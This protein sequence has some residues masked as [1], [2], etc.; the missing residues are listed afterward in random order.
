MKTKNS[1]THRKN[2]L[3]YVKKLAKD[4]HYEA[5]HT[6]QVT[7]TALKIFDD[8]QNLHRLGSTERFYLECAGILHDIGVHTQGTKGHHKAS[9]N[10]ILTTPILQFNNIER[11]IIGSVVR[12]HRRA[13]PSISHDHFK[14]L[15]E[16]ERKKV[17]I[18]AGILRIADGLDYT[19][20]RHVG[21]VEASFNDHKIIIDCLVRRKPIKK[22]LKS[23][24]TK[25]T[26]LTSLFN[27]EL[28]LRIHEGEEFSGWS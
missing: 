27:R 9:L 22:E 7:R 24:I 2:E 1:D 3:K 15:N 18:L 25:G 20:R 14:A 28:V 17:S 21:H 10:I 6:R 12:Y 16:D 8:L 26:L 23:A 19:H 4:C 11:L 13:M 5:K